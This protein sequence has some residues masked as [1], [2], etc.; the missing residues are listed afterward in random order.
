V[1]KWDHDGYDSNH[2]YFKI[3]LNM[4]KLLWTLLF[5]NLGLQVTLCAQSFHATVDASGGNAHSTDG[6]INYSVGQIQ[7]NTISAFN[8]KLS[9]GVQQP[10]ELYKI[11]EVYQ[12]NNDQATIHLVHQR[13]NDQLVLKMIHP[14]HTQLTYQLYDDMGKIIEAHQISNSETIINMIN[15]P[16]GFYCLIINSKNRNIKTFKIIKGQ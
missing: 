3:V 15:R 5:V 4:S 10:F 6:S 14:I 11:T 2:H 16:Q 13:E 8:G 7:I 1:N 9:S 12:T